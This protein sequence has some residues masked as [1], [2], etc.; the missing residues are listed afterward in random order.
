MQYLVRVS[1]IV[2]PFWACLMASLQDVT[3][4]L[5]A[6]HEILHMFYHLRYF[7]SMNMF[8]QSVQFSF[9]DVHNL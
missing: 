4:T 1:I 2:L 6:T 3:V 7:K 5:Q 8:F 9:E